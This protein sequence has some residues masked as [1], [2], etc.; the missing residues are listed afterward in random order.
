MHAGTHYFPRLLPVSVCVA[1][2][3]LVSMSGCKSD[4]AAQDQALVL[5]E[6]KI[7]S[8]HPGQAIFDRTCFAC[9]SIG[10]GPRVGPDLKNVH[11]RR[12]GDWLVRW[13]EDPLGMAKNDS[14]GKALLAEWKVPM[15]PPNLSRDEI[16]QVLEYIQLVSMGEVAGREAEDTGPVELSEADF[17]RGQEIFFDRCAGCHGTLR[18]GATGPNIQ[19]ARTTQIGTSALKAILTSGTPGGMPAWGL[20][21]VLS[22]E[23]IELM[24]KYVQLEPPAP[25]AKPLSE[26]R[27]SW[28]LR[29]PV[30][31]RPTSPQTKR[32]WENFF[33]VILRDA[34]KVA[35]LDGDTYELVS[36]IN[37]GFAVHILRSS[38]TGRY[39]YA[40]GRDGRVTL[41]DL[42][43]KDPSLVAQVQGCIDARSVEG[44][45]YKGYEDRYLI[46]GCYWPTQFVV[47]DGLTL[48]PLS[49]TGVE[50][51]AIRTNEPLKEV[52]VAAIIA[53]HTDPVW[54]V[55]LKE[56]GH[57]AI[58]DYSKKGFP[59]VSR[60]PAERFLHDGGW[61]HT[62]RYFLVA[63]NME[64]KMAVIDVQEQKLVTTF[65]TGIK[66]HPGRGAN[67]EDPEFGWV[68]GTTHIGQGL[69]AVYGADP[70]N[71]PEHAWK[72]VRQVTL[73]G[74]GSL[75]LKTHANSPWVWFDMPLNNDPEAARKVCVYSKQ[76]GVV[77]RCWSVAD[78]GAAT[79]FE[80]NRAGTEVW[81]SV[82]DRAGELVVY[83]DKTLK[84]KRRIKGDWLV[85]PT[86]K[87]NV[88]NTAEDIY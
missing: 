15:S 62:G 8:T 87:F 79:H 39:F 32:N 18:A 48:E 60:I 41:I 28:E 38:S 25:P 64:N 22:A 73:D 74:T 36:V 4:R 12:T 58:V 54:V 50:G 71:H 46:E 61:D 49:V 31:D 76:K 1:L 55:A 5:P 77:D 80:F 42:W 33:G 52:R 35:I 7:A 3:A 45:K 57:V 37:T 65:E 19:P 59:V 40:V 78:H 44:S 88:H 67:W 63:A 14:I 29:I 53:S 16:D 70:V 75:F 20:S 13:L 56:S 2:A 83:D 30:K 6:G 34:G 68:N 47:Y 85:T 21:G 23:E 11:E 69:L 43:T 26:I 86:G 82:W 9:H 66:P 17:K 81:V 51:S 72:V 27:N 24:A 10:E 84:E